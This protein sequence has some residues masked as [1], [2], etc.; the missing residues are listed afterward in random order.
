MSLGTVLW[1]SMGLIA[2]RNKVL[3]E[4]FEPIM[5]HGPNTKVSRSSAQAPLSSVLVTHSDVKWH[6]CDAVIVWHERCPRL[7][8]V[9]DFSHIVGAPHPP[10]S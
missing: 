9:R 8:H 10:F 6:I 1:M 7:Q 2:Y 4:I 3:L 5:Q